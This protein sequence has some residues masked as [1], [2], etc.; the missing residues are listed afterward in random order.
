[1]KPVSVSLVDFIAKPFL[2]VYLF[3]K[4]QKAYS[5]YKVHWI[6]GKV[7]VIFEEFMKTHSNLTDLNFSRGPM[8]LLYNKNLALL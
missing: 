7:S 3:C 6:K 2:L 1:M 8:S 4:P 5:C